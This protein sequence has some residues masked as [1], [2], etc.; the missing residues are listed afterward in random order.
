M[1]ASERRTI[2]TKLFYFATKIDIKFTTF[3]YEKKN[4]KESLL[5]DSL[6][7][8]A[9]I[10]KDMNTF[11]KCNKRYFERFGKVILYSDNGQKNITRILNT[12]LATNFNEYDIRKVCPKD[13]KLF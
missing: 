11:I 3:V 5:K 10:V 12:I 4:F 7:L 2:L 13:Y 9:E 6:K 8:E 1:D